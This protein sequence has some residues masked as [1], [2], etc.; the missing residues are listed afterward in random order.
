MIWFLPIRLKCFSFRREIPCKNNIFNL[1]M[2]RNRGEGHFLITKH[3][4]RDQ[5]GSY[6][7]SVSGAGSIDRLK[8]HSKS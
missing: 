8:A 6:P 1:I 4:K 5:E 3:R 2:Q 7:L